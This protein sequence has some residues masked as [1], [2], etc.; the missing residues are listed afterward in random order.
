VRLESSNAHGPT[1]TV[2][3]IEE[4]LKQQILRLLAEGDMSVGEIAKELDVGPSYIHRI[5]RELGQR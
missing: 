4:S 2:T 5:K 3:T 1:W